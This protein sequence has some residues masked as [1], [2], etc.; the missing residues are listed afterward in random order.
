MHLTAYSKS[1]HRAGQLLSPKLLAMKLTVILLIAGLQV[2][3]S[4]FSQGITL[5]EKNI[6]LV[7]LFKKIEKQ[8]GYSFVYNEEWLK[9]SGTIT[10]DVKQVTFR[11]ALDACFYGLPFSYMIIERNIFVQRRQASEKATGNIEVKGRVTSE[12]DE[13]LSGA[14][15]MVKGTGN[16]VFTNE[17]GEFV[18]TDL[19]PDAVLIISSVSFETQEI[20]VN[21]RNNIAIKLKVKSSSL[22]SVVISYNT[23]Y[24]YI[25]KERAT[26]SF[27]HVDNALFNRSVSTNVLDRLNGVT[28]GLLFD[29]TAGNTLG[30]SIRGRST[31]FSSTEPL[32]I[33][34]NFPYDGNIAN[35]NPNDIES[36][37]VLKDA[38]AASIWGARSG[39]GVIV[40]TTKRGRLNQPIQLEFNTNF[41]VSEKPDL[42]YNQQ[43]LNPSDFIDVEKMLFK[44]G[45]YDGRLNNMITYPA[46]TPVVNILN[47]QRLGNI[48]DAE[49]T[50][51]IDALKNNDVRNDLTKYFYRKPFN[52]QYA[53]NIRGGSDK[54]SYFFSTGYDKNLPQERGAEYGRV[55]LNSLITFYPVRNL[56]IKGGVNY[57]QHNSIN[58]SV[59]NGLI[60]GGSL[61]PYAQLA[62]A[63]GHAL[64]VYKYFRKEFVDE[65]TS[66]GLL[67]WSYYPLN[68]LG[69]AN[70]RSTLS[71]TRLIAG[72]KYSFLKGLSSEVNYQY[73]SG[74]TNGRTLNSVQ[75]YTARQLINQYSR[76][77]GGTVVY[78]NIPLGGILDFSNAELISNAIRGQVNYSNKWAAHEVNVIAGVEAREAK[79]DGHS[80]RLYGYDEGTGAYKEVDFSGTHWYQTYPSGNSSV[81]PNS[82][83][84][85]G[86]IDRYRSYFANLA[87][88]YLSKYTLS[89]SARKD[90][91]NLF[92]V[93]TNQKG[94]PL[95]SV[96]GKWSVNDE[97]FY[98]INW[99]PYLKARVTYG[100]NGNINKTVTAYTVA[101]YYTNTWLNNI[102]FAQILFPGNPDLRWEKIRMWNAGVDFEFAKI[103]SGSIDLF[104]KKGKDVI[105][106][107][108]V[109]TSTGF[110]S[111]RGNYAD[112]EGKG[113]DVI[114]NSKNIDKKFQWVTT[115]LLS[116]AT[117]KITKYKG[118][119]TN[120]IIVEGNPF[121]S[122]YA[123][124][125]AGLDKEGN[126]QGL[127]DDKPSIDYS[128]ILAAAPKDM[129]NY[130][131]QPRFFGAL[132]NT[133]SYKGFS[134]SVSIL[135][136]AGYYFQHSTIVYEQLY[137][138][139]I[140][141][142][143]FAKRWQKAGD[144]RITT[145]P[146]MIYP[147]NLERDA[148]YGSS[149][150]V[151]SRGDHIRLQD[152]NLNYNLS[153]RDW[154]SLPVNNIQVYVYANNL[155]VLWKA[156]KEKIDPDTVTGIPLMR[157]VSL[158]LRVGF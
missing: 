131:L 151:I 136:K 142:A 48:T 145:V 14:T 79:T 49:A 50:T 8:T 11:Q 102:N 70:S 120:A 76:I 52:Q 98:R 53:L 105:G 42:F 139:G 94:V 133:F 47:Q 83:G 19:P 80:S 28:S 156:N 46:I 86:T 152:I 140:G 92:G 87:Y 157:S 10:I 125:W 84:V 119:A 36:I 38:A 111:V 1:W 141:H 116:Y 100:Y 63:G 22:D 61:Y 112:I 81:I 144:E 154:H 107:D 106:D 118:V 129:A 109:P 146:A 39:N 96:G 72:I 77:E 127:V 97:S 58:N 30:I 23:G 57:S 148:F 33:V 113:I 6:S 158:G 35:I 20:K 7:D 2:S 15:V 91:S 110:Q 66:K 143:D 27:A 155:G 123:Y 153:R 73:E 24:Q 137:N 67:D 135:Y 99:L 34:D 32:I 124:H 25:P 89:A 95:W 9:S 21:N 74:L 12:N 44:E 90:E 29:A 5:S 64:P 117:D 78:R 138:S 45:F 17:N 82:A 134:L 101:A 115:F 18:L 60:Y 130:N 3:A 103:I 37:T 16:I 69:Y 147:N 122:V 4:G 108:P 128:A 121:N 51:Q 56:E 65:A 55:T 59:A 126:P 85:T 88:T 71:D 104:R 62:D 26:G 149:E 93:T 13:P 41:T 31:I 68:E 54:V 132:R 75:T 43:F 114:L 150:A 40:I